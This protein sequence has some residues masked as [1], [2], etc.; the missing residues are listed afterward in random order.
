MEKICWANTENFDESD[1]VIVGIPDESQSHALRQGTE[2]APSKIRE[3]SNL[4][5]YT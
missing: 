4:R 1:F 5:E 3:I 2:E